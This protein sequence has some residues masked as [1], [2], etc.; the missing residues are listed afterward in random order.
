QLASKPTV[1]ESARRYREHIREMAPDA[2]RISDKMPTNF[3]HL[4]LISCMFPAARVVHCRRDPVDTCLSCWMQHFAGSHPYASDLT[5]VGLFWNEYQRVMQHWMDVLPNPILEIDYEAVV[6]Q[7]EE[8]SR[9]LVDFVGLPWSDSCLHFHESDRVNLTASHAQ[10]RRPIYRSAVR[11]WKHYEKH[12]A[13]L[14]DALDL[15]D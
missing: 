9:R 11:R 3:L 15:Q 12:L 5:H 7:Q 2:A 8:E 4:G 10:V 14:R 1:S 13:P 6:E